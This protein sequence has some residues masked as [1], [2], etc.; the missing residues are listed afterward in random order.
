MLVKTSYVP[1]YLQCQIHFYFFIIGFEILIG[2]LQSSNLH[3]HL[4]IS[5]EDNSG[6]ITD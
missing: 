5:Y 2:G 6:N 3:D 4:P 1:L